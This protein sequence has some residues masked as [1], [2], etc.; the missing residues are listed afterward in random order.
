MQ[1]VYAG[2]RR[3]QAGGLARDS[4]FVAM[5]QGAMT[6]ADL[7]QIVVITRV[8]GLE[9]YGRLAVAMA[10]VL[11]IGQL[12]DLRVGVA[13]TVIGARRIQE[14]PRRSAGVFQFTY[15]ID[16]GTGVVGFAIVAAL[17][18]IIG[19]DLVG[20]DGALLMLL[21]AIT[22]LVSTLDESSFSVL[23]LFD[24]FPLIAASNT[25]IELLRVAAVAGAV[26][27]FKSLAAV[28]VALV[29]ARSVGA[30]V[31]GGLAAR[32]FKRV[33]GRSLLRPALDQAADVR[34]EMWH[35]MLHTNVVSY[36]RVAQTQL[37]TVLIG[38]LATPVQ[39][40]AYKVGM[41][42]A[43]LI[44]KLGDPA[45]TAILPRLARLWSEGAYEPLRRLIRLV[46]VV[47]LPALTVGALI[48][49]VLREPALRLL[50]GDKAAASAQTVLV[51]G[52]VAHA[53]NSGLFWNG[54]LLFAAGRSAFVSRLSVFA[55]LLQVVLLLPFVA[56]WGANGAALALLVTFVV[57]NL[58]ATR[59]ALQVLRSP[60]P[61]LT[62][63]RPAEP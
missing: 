26:L 27:A 35:M 50:G 13:A 3:T 38:A 54:S 53:V 61:L 33:T 19:P 20:E 49:I 59:S 17:A 44:A 18:P 29:A 15:L 23:R 25:M 57:I 62:N 34:S 1:E 8:L 21:F 28:V 45:Y 48:L 31:N 36:A 4:L 22:L 16:G 5:Y 37:P 41:G 10:A 30:L 60:R 12:F 32:T 42:A 40:G 24:R 14:D 9:E 55:A 63:P 47:A 51:L 2:W 56:A 52:A 39:V 7:V 58:V 43:L 46:A 11:V 6:V